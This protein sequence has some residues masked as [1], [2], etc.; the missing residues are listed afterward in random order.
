MTTVYRRFFN[1]HIASPV[2]VMFRGFKTSEYS[3]PVRIQEKRTDF[4]IYQLAEQYNKKWLLIKRRIMEI[5][6][7]K[8]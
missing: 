1:R 7:E 6:R 4:E 5:K 8:E 3:T 2:N